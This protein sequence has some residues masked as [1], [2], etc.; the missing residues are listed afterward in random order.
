MVEL[1]IA[2]QLLAQDAA[3]VEIAGGKIAYSRDPA[4][5]LQGLLKATAVDR[6]V[7]KEAD[8]I[9]KV[10]F[11]GSV[12]LGPTMKSLWARSRSACWKFRQ[13]F[14]SSLVMRTPRRICGRRSASTGGAKNVTNRSAR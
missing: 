12:R 3:V 1:D 8:G 10:G 5:R 9:K 13:F 14:I 4:T 2:I 11:P 6:E 7:A